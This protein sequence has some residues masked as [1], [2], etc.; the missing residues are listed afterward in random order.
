MKIKDKINFT[1]FMGISNQL[2]I[3]V[4]LITEAERVPK[5]YGIKLTVKFTYLNDNGDEESVNK[6]AFTNL[7]KTSEPES[8]IGI[9]CPFILNLEPTTIKGVNS[10]V[11]IMVG[12]HS[13]FGLQINPAD[14][15]CGAKLM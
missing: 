11:M 12:D 7:G 6:I 5:S 4:G 2:D 14:Y 3:R 1:K 13:K 9:Q 10:E 8:L 15:S